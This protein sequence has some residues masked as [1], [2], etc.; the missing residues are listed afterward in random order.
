[1]AIKEVDNMP[2]Y[3]VYGEMTLRGYWIVDADSPSDAEYD[4]DAG[5]APEMTEVTDIPDWEVTGVELN[6]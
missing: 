6:E 4:V 5:G 3:I 1:M 2:S